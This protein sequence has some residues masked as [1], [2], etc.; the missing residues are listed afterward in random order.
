MVMIGHPGRPECACNGVIAGPFGD[1]RGRVAPSASL[2]RS[3]QPGDAAE[4]LP[5][6]PDEPGV[7]R[8]A[9]TPETLAEG[10]HAG[11]AQQRGG[12]QIGHVERRTRE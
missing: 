8:P 10:V 9:G 4:Q 3:G 12:F 6:G 11:V 2:A 5:R 7:V 1:L